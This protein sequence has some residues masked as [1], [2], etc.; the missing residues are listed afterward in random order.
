MPKLVTDHVGEP[1]TLLITKHISACVVI[2]ESKMRALATLRP[3]LKA[4]PWLVSMQS[5]ALCP[6]KAELNKS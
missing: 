6:T 2:S 1:V 4:L 3:C 5:W